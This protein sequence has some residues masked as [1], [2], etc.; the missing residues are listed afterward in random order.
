MHG[1]DDTVSRLLSHRL[2]GFS[3]HEG[4]LDGL[5][6][7]LHLDVAWIEIDT[8]QTA[9]GQVIVFHDTRLERITAA[10]GRV[11]DY[12]I[13]ASG[14]LLYAAASG[15]SVPTLEAFLEKF[16]ASRISTKL[17]IDIKDPGTEE[18]HVELIRKYGLVSH[19]W[20]IAWDPQI[21]V[22]THQLAP[23]LPLGFS[24]V[25]MTGL[26]VLFSRLARIAGDGALIR[27]AGRRLAW[28]GTDH[29]LQDVTV[30]RE[31]YNNAPP[32]ISGFPIHLL[33]ELP[34]GRLGEILER[35]CGGVG[36]PAMLLT[37]TYVRQ[38]HD[39][40]FKVFVYSIDSFQKAQQAVC[41]CDP[42]IIFTNRSE[43]FRGA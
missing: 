26:R 5:S 27:W 14:P 28:V 20:I 19:I 25:P 29:N 24:H 9:D 42:D 6:A 39:R 1:S 16:A 8:R 22:R 11:R 43:L 4:S 40:G 2:S 32:K 15:Y 31:S 41:Q 34:T 38:A 37:S 21:L 23:E 3:P 36:L 7:A 10:K 17:M 30:Y 18:T 12:S 35:T 33:E 13:S